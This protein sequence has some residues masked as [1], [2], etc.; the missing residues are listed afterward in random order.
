MMHRIVIALAAIAAFAGGAR[1]DT[2]PS[3]PV[4]MIVQFNPGAVS[5]IIGRV[6]A[7][8]L[9]QKLGQ[10]F[11]VVNREGAGGVIGN[12]AVAQARPDGYTLL[13]AV[14][15]S[16][17]AQPHIVK[18]IP[19]TIDSFAPICQVFETQFIAI[20]SPDSPLKS[21]ADLV[22]AARAAPGKH[23]Y[24]VFGVG[25]VPHLQFHS[26]LM[27]AKVEMTSVPYRSIS[28]L[29]TDTSSRQLDVG[30]TSF[31]SLGAAPVRIMVGLASKR[32]EAYPDAPSTGELGYPVSD[33][34]F[35]GLLAPKGTPREILNTLE[36]ACGAAMQAPRMNDVM[37]RTGSPNIFA[38]GAEYEKHLRADFEAKG[39][40]VRAL[41][42]KSQ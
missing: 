42:L 6:L 21:L 38:S 14:A 8:E 16:F 31:G 9:S 22:Q 12:T 11:I 28:Q 17:T 32:N 25:S 2:Y 37:K 34:N 20:T 24:G 29:V 13:F 5:D 41:N 39:A 18:D 1:A 26:L 23:T 10:P 7:D 15:G 4:Q 3:K 19:Y 33:P 30:V 27:A 36:T 35:T 40:L